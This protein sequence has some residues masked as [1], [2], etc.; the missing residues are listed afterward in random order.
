MCSSALIRKIG[1]LISTPQ[2]IDLRENVSVDKT[3]SIENAS[4]ILPIGQ[5]ILTK[6]ECQVMTPILMLLI[7]WLCIVSASPVGK[8]LGD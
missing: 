7:V 6:S 4:Y 2:Y 8:L 5:N 1:D 3:C